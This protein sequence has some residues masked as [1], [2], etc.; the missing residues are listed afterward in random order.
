[1]NSE[2]TKPNNASSIAR[3]AQIE[4]QPLTNIHSRRARESLVLQLADQIALDSIFKFSVF[5]R[6]TPRSRC[7]PHVLVKEPAK[8]LTLDCFC[9]QCGG[10]SFERT[11]MLR[12]SLGMRKVDLFF[13][14]R[15]EVV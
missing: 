15:R 9:R 13:L 1:M 11:S 5:V 6:K 2:R 3:T 7:S 4:P 10:S 8:S 14:L 12:V